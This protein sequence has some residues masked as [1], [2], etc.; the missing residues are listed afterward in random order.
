M[1]YHSTIRKESRMFPGV[2]YEIRRPSLRSRLELLRLVRQEGHSLTFHN[3]S[4]EFADQLRAKEVLTSIEAIYIQ[5]GLLRI[6]DL[7]I[8]N[9]PADCELLIEKGPEALCREIAES[10]REECFLSEEEQKN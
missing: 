9:H 3:A 7:S 4:D 10:I 8:D 6:V 1:M 2:A 5:W